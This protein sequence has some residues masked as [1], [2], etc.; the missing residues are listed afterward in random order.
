MKSQLFIVLAVAV[1]ECGISIW[2][3]AH[4]DIHEGLCK[5]TMALS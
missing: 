4:M 3:Q 1:M 2:I 5:T